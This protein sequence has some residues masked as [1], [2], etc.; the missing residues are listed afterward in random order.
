MQIH[1]V[2]VLPTQ[3]DIAVFTIG[4]RPENILEQ[5]FKTFSEVEAYKEALDI[6]QGSEDELQGLTI[7]GSTVVYSISRD[8]DDPEE[9][10]ITFLT[11][12]EAIAFSAG[13]EDFDGFDSPKLFTA[14]D[15]DDFLRLKGYVETIKAA[16]PTVVIYKSADQ[17]TRVISS[18]EVRVIVLDADGVGLEEDAS[19]TL[20]FDD[21]ELHVSDLWISGPV[22]SSPYGEQGINAEFVGQVAKVVQALPADSQADF[23]KPGQFAEPFPTLKSVQ[24][25]ARGISDKDASPATHQINIDDQ[26]LTSGEVHLSVGALDG[27]ADDVLSVTADVSSSPQKV[28]DQVPTLQVRFNASAPAFTAFKLADKILIRPEAGVELTKIMAP[29]GTM[30]IVE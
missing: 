2:F 1:Q 6:Y 29:E 7:E 8:G 26:R 24:V 11:N 19:R 27:V 28:V 10:S 9:E 5:S 23:N 22:G 16:V 18:Q 13:V 17:I 30:Y 14:E 3:A 12:A 20:K 21:Q 15:G 4:H 25:K